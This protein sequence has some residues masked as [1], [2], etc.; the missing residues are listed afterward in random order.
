MKLQPIKHAPKT[1]STAA[2]VHLRHDFECNNVE[3]LLQIKRGQTQRF[4]YFSLRFWIANC[5]TIFVPV[6]AGLLHLILTNVMVDG[7]ISGWN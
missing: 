4:D 1:F 2:S 6:F 3:G 7:I 5:T